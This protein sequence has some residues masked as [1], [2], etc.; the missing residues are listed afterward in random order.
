[1]WNQF[2]YLPKLIFACYPMKL[3]TNKSDWKLCIRFLTSK[4]ELQQNLQPL[5]MPNISDPTA[6]LRPLSDLKEEGAYWLCHDVHIHLCQEGPCH[7]QRRSWGRT[8]AP[9]VAAGL[10]RVGLLEGVR[11][12]DTIQCPVFYLLCLFRVRDDDTIQ[13]HTFPYYITL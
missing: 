13:C 2:R 6:K 7:L 12:N 11:D 10:R 9:G 8:T 5:P 1:M 3:K 4:K